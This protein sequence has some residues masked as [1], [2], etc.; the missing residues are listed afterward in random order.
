M[1]KIIIYGAGL[2]FVAFVVGLLLF[3]TVDNAV[4][5]QAVYGSRFGVFRV[6]GP[7][8][9]LVNVGIFGLVCSFLSYIVFLFN[10]SQI[11][12]TIYKFI[13]VASGFVIFLGLA[14]GQA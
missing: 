14:W 8:S 1:S 2:V 11:L 12:L 6:S 4:S 5:G 10:R 7:A 13:G 3:L 9:I